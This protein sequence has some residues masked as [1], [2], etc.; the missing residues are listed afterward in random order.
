[1]SQ[2]TFEPGDRVWLDRYYTKGQPGTG[3][4]TVWVHPGKNERPKGTIIRHELNNGVPNWWLVKVDRR[5]RFQIFR[6]T[7]H[8]PTEAMTRLDL[9]DTLADLGR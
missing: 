7:M 1:M 5:S 3:V 9:M 4:F 8:L 6:E 2:K